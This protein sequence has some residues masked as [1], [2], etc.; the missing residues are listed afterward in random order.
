MCADITYNHDMLLVTR[1][2]CSAMYAWYLVQDVIDRYTTSTGKC[3]EQFCY[4]TDMPVSNALTTHTALNKRLIK[5]ENSPQTN[6][7]GLLTCKAR[8]HTYNIDILV[9]KAA[10]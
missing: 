3:V 9:V 1:N 6:Q 7:C 8:V 5:M 4:N 2:K 10:Y